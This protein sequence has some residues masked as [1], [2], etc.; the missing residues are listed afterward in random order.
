MSD[1]RGRGRPSK[2]RPLL[3]AIK[4]SD[5]WTVIDDKQKNLSAPSGMR[6]R[7]P[8]YQFLCRKRE[9]GLYDLLARHASDA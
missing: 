3:E 9:D 4:P 5:D 7:Y 1:G 6:A 2:Y 8:L